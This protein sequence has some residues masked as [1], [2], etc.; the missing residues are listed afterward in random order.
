MKLLLAALLLTGC[1]TYHKNPKIN[2]RGKPGNNGSS[3]TTRQE[4]TGVYVECG[5]GTI[6]FIKFPDPGKPGSACSV[7]D[8][9]L[10]TCSDGSAYQIKN[11]EDGEDCDLT[12][13]HITCSSNRTKKFKQYLKCGEEEIFIKDVSIRGGC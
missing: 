13:K 10:V 6:S 3:C 11:G 5:D 2:L 9:G 8:S 4:S 12:E 1:G 7:N